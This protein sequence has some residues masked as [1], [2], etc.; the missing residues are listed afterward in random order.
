M[1]EFID[2]SIELLD[3]QLHA[4]ESS[5]AR[6]QK[7]ELWRKIKPELNAIGNRC[8]HLAGSEYQHI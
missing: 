5:V 2:R 1:R 3:A 6:L 4:V 8:L 7:E